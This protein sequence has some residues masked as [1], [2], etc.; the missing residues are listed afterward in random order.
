MRKL[1][2]LF[3]AVTGA[4]AAVEA[5]ACIGQAPW[6]SGRMK[7]GGSLEIDGGT[8][9]LGGIGLGKDQGFFVGA[10]AGI[11]DYA[12][13]GNSHLALAGG[14]GKELSQ[15]LADQIS[16]CPVANLTWVLPKDEVSQQTVVAGLSGGYPLASG[17]KNLAIILTGAGQLGFTHTKVVTAGSTDFVGVIDAGAGFIFNNRI[18]L[19]PVVRIYFG[20]GSDVAFAVRVNV[21]VGK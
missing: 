5:Q 3:L 14:V 21:P 18:S 1:A 7:V 15:K 4:P 10:G 8:T 9:L 19:V 2:L 20:N 6:S 16:L 13:P 12:G 17:S 11:V